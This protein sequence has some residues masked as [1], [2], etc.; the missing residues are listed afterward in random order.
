M[1]SSSPARNPQLQLVA[2]QPTTGECWIPAKK[3]DTPHPRAKEKPQQDCRAGEITFKIKLHTFQRCL[4]SLNI[5]MCA[6]GPRDPT[7][8]EPDLPLSIS[9]FP[10]EVQVSNGLPQGQGLWVWEIWVIHRVT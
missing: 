7:E 3:K 2:E 10:V 9:V 8:T 6:P 4:E 5:T 1:C